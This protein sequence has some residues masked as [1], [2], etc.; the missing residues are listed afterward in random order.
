M[1]G[2]AADPV[3]RLASVEDVAK[4]PALEIKAGS[5]FRH[6]G[7]GAVA[8]DP[9]PSVAE[10][11]IHQRDGRCLVAADRSDPGTVIG[12][13]IMEEVD[14]GGHIHQVSADPDHRGR[15]IGRSLIERAERWAGDRG[16]R[17]MTLTTFVEVPWNGPYYLGL[18][19]RFLD[20]PELV[21]RLAAI[22][23][24]EAEA[25]LDRWPRSAMVKDL[26]TGNP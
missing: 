12:Y 17:T 10:L 25:G 19:Y 15:R 5:L 9:P 26:I 21:G 11:L 22:R 20:D 13:L 18:G 24:A 16:Y 23:K 1:M 7:M 6:H 2:P 8:D 3:L 14:G 4:L